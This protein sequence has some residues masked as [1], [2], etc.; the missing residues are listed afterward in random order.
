VQGITS[1]QLNIGT[2]YTIKKIT[3]TDITRHP[4]ATFDFMTSGR[5]V[6]RF[7]ASTM[8]IS[9]K[10]FDT[11]RAEAKALIERIEAQQP[12]AS[13]WLHSNMLASVFPVKKVKDEMDKNITITPA[14]I[15]IDGLVEGREAK[16]ELLSV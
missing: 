13:V 8:D 11:R 2:E 5:V 3:A 6:Q 14:G 10:P 9:D 16:L 15:K 7:G 1:P 4:G 12:I